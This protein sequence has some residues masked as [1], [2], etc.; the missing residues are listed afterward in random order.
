VTGTLA[1]V[2]GGEFGPGCTFDGELLEASG[3]DSVLVLPT[4]AAFEHPERSVQQAEAW[5]AELGAHVDGLMV[6]RRSE[7][8]L[9]EHAAQA[10][11][12]R[13]TYVVGGSPMHL[14]SVLKDTPLWEAM[15]DALTD[16]G[17]LAGSVAGAMVFSDPMVDPRGGAFTLGLGLV[18]PLAVVPQVEH[19]SADR[20]HRTLDLADEDHDHHVLALESAS[21][22]IRGPD[23][24]WRTHGRVTVYR[25]HT[26]VGLEVLPRG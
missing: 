21:A 17:V 3:G 7:A 25:G 10:R 20:L 26:P 14:R 9:P 19:W 15:Q 11:A 6:M 2:G 13:F 12:S 1:L 5:F 24:G 18:R 4:A 16:G 8:F 23:G 22:A